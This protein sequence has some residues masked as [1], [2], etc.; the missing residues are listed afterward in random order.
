MFAKNSVKQ[1]NS[2]KKWSTNESG[3][4]TAINERFPNA[5][6]LTGGNNGNAPDL[7]PTNSKLTNIEIKSASA[8]A[9]EFTLQVSNGV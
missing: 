7:E 1:V 3:A 6:T 8:R 2:T 5:Y 4:L 9:A